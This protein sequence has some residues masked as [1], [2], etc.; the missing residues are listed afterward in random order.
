MHKYNFILEPNGREGG[1]GHAIDLANNY[2][3]SLLFLFLSECSL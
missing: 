1:A 3:V 2:G